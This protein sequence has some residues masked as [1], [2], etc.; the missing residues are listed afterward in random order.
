MIDMLTRLLEAYKSITR[1]DECAWMVLKNH[2]GAPEVVTADAGFG[3]SADHDSAL[4]MRLFMV[5]ITN[6]VLN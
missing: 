2:C 1:T 6:N 5:T 4:H 3:P